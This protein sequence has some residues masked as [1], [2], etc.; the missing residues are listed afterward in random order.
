M[1]PSNYDWLY[2]ICVQAQQREVQTL[3][4]GFFGNFSISYNGLEAPY[5]LLKQGHLL[6][7]ARLARDLRRSGA[8]RRRGIAYALARP[9]LPD[10]TRQAINGIRAGFSRGEED[11]LIQPEFARAN[12]LDSA[13]RERYFEG[14]NSQST[15]VQAMRRH[16]QGPTMEAF[17][18]MSGV[19]MTDP[20]MDRRVIE[21]CLS[22]P[23]EHYCEKGIPRSLIRNAMAGLLP[24]QLRT[25]RRKGQQAADFGEHFRAERQ[26]AI[27]EIARMRKIEL[28]VRALDI[29]TIESMIHWSDA[30]IAAYGWG[31]YWSRFMRALSLGRFLYR[32][33]D[34]TLLS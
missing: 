2:E 26:E 6:R 27:D 28:A 13:A 23:I 25:E 14:G 16:D 7:T 19:S 1:N 31:N 15:R 29:S 21:Y 32:A 17:R 5:S 33:E 3:Q 30:Q 24:E 10:W 20:T 11:S 8:M 18:Q 4:T 12:G 9:W 34:G 22:V